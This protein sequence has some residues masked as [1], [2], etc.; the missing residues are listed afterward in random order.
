[1]A[2]VGELRLERAMAALAGSTRPI[3]EIAHHELGAQHR[4]GVA[5]REIVVDNDPIAG[6]GQQTR[7]MASDVA[8]TAGYQKASPRASHVGS[9]R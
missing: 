5:A 7:D 3:A 4:P 6:R 9:S 2:H 8:G 1:M